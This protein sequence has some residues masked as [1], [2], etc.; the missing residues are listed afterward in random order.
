MPLHMQKGKLRGPN[1]KKS[2]PF[3]RFRTHTVPVNV[4]SLVAF[5]SGSVV[6]V[7][8]LEARGLVNGNRSRRW[9]IKILARGD[10][11]RALTVR[12]HAFSAGARIKIEAAGGRAEVIPARGA[13]AAAEE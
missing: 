12:A 3:E 7:E 1:H 9:P 11:D 10:L 13:G 4:G 2:M 5:D 8:A 6:D